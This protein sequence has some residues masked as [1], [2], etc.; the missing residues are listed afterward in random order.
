VTT[1]TTPDRGRSD[2]PAI[3]LIGCGAIAR[4]FHLPAL[5]RDPRLLER[6]VLVDRD[7]DRARAL[8]RDFGVSDV[9]A[10][11]RE[12]IGRVDGAIVLTPHHLHFPIALAFLEEGRSVLCE[13]PLAEH[14]EEVRRLVAVA[15][16]SGAAVAVN[17]TRR[18]IPACAKA[19]ELVRAGAIGRLCAIDFAEGD[20]FD[21]PSASSS[22]FGLHGSGKGVVLDIGAHI[23]D[24]VCWWAGGRPAVTGYRDDSYGGSEAVAHAEMEL[25]GCRISVRLSWLSKLRNSYLLRGEGGT[26]EGG[27]YDWRKLTL[28][29][30]RGRRRTVVAQP[31]VR[32]YPELARPLIDNFV[33]VLRGTA[34]PLVS[35]T[36]VL[37][38]IELIEECYARRTRFPMPWDD[39]LDRILPA[40]A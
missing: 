5:A 10:D 2:P 37:P 7:L 19:A 23:F 31:N 29:D 36:D 21:W 26:I 25:A 40:Y 14:A 17:N 22:T 3:A 8:G 20:K 1:Q 18:L 15:R 13:K 33:D 6:L 30:A 34:A 4:S 9:A 39:T 35:G 32:T 27:I 16:G 11:Y 28:T 24:L 38:S 12:V